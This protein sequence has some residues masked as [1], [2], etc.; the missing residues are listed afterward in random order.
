MKKRIFCDSSTKEACYV[1]EGESPCIVPY[2]KLVTNNVGE[3]QAVIVALKAAQERGFNDVLVLSDSQLV[4]RQVQGLYSCKEEH[5]RF[6]R[7]VVW[8]LLRTLRYIG[9]ADVDWIPREEN[10][11]GK[12]LS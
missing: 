12:V 2:L 4:V 9:T 6:Y 1:I 3:Y 10:P 8:V 11:A 7:Q 5:L